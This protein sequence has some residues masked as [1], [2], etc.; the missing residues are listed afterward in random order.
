[1]PIILTLFPAERRWLFK[2]GNDYTVPVLD[3]IVATIWVVLISEIL[4]PLLSERFTADWKD[5]VFYGIGSFI[6]HFTMNKVSLP[7]KTGKRR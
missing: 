4:F 6:F 2:K 7:S 5:V 3:I 1:M